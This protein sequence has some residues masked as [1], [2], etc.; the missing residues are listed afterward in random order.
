LSAI[1]SMV[2]VDELGI[3]KNSCNYLTVII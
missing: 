2:V 1:A 3:A